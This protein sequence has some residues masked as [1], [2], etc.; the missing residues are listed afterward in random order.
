M[1]IAKKAAKKRR[2]QL[3]MAFLYGEFRK[4]KAKKP[5][6]KFAEVLIERKNRG[7][8]YFPKP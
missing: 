8:S 5:N 6:A 2:R 7:L 1:D 4:L 3:K